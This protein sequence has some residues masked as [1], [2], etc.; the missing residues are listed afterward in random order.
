MERILQLILLWA[1]LFGA[2]AALAQS[3]PM[4]QFDIPPAD[5]PTAVQKFAATIG[6]DAVFDNYAARNA[7]TQAVR[8]T[9]TAES[10]LNQMLAGTG[11]TYRYNAVARRVVVGRHLESVP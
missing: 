6:G 8:G 3:S 10:A 2:S 9:M 4:F 7:R 1:A 11:L 5:L